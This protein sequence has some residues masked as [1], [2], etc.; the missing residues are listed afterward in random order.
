[1]APRDDRDPLLDDS[2]C[3]V[4]I[5][6]IMPGGQFMDEFEKTILSWAEATSTGETKA[7]GNAALQALILATEEAFKNPDPS[8]LLMQEADDLENKSAWS[9]A[10]AVR[11]KTL[12]SAEADGNLGLLVKAQMD[13]CGLLRLLGRTD[14]AAPFACAATASA[15]RVGIL[16]L[17]VMALGCEAACA[18]DQADSTRALAAATEALKLI[19]PGKL[20]DGTRAKARTTR[21]RCLLANGDPIA[22]GLELDESWG[23]LQAHSASW[24]AMMPGPI[25]AM[26]NWWEVKSQLEEQRGNLENAQA[27]LVQAINF[28][29]RSEGPYALFALARALETSGG[30]S[31]A[32][33]DLAGE[34]RSLN[35]A[36]SI[37]IGLHLPSGM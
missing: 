19:E 32:T 37:R 14:D 9:E 29:R 8:L 36:Q 10:E 1:M 6:D 4:I 31:R 5:F 23:P 20:H 30:I 25:R 7:A 33:G 18:L 15:R 21:A 27:A 16:P 17:V 24:M 26:G 13:L 11:R 28:R 12:A 35:E 2:Q 22:A 3:L 34:A